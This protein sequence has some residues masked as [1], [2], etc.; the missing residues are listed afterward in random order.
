MLYINSY[1]GEFKKTNLMKL[2]EKRII[3]SLIYFTCLILYNNNNNSNF[4][5][6]LNILI[7]LLY[8]NKWAIDNN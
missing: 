7:R 5:T 6:T 8:H 4:D 3:Y 1:N 2:H